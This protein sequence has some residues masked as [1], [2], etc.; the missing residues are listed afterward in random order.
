MLQF[1]KGQRISV[2]LFFILKTPEALK[3]SNNYL[4]IMNN[5]IQPNNFQTTDNK[6]YNFEKTS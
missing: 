3:M 6:F 1:F 4:L 2:F 5:P